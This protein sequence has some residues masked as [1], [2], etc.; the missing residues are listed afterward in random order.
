MK[1][2][3]DTKYMEKTKEELISLLAELDNPVYTF[4]LTKTVFFD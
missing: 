2:I 4:P 3:I 1:D